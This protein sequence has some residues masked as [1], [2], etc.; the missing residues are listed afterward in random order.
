MYESRSDDNTAPGRETS[1]DPGWEAAKG[2]INDVTLLV[3]DDAA[4]RL[5][6]RFAG[7]SF[8]A[9]ILL[10]LLFD[11][12]SPDNSP[13]PEE[14]KE[15]K[16]R[17]HRAENFLVEDG[18]LW[19]LR[20]GSAKARDKVECI[21]KAETK[22]LALAVHSAGGHFGRDMTILALQLRYFWPTL[23][24]DVVETITSCPRWKNVGPRLLSAQL[25]PITRARPFDLIVGDYLSM[26]QGFN[27]FKTVLVLVNVYSRFAF[28]FPL[29]GPG[30]GKSTVNGLS[31]VADMLLMPRTFLAD[32]GSHFDCEEVREWATK[33]G[34]QL[35]KTPTYAPWTNGLAEG[36][37][38]LLIGRLKRLCAALLGQSDEEDGDPSSTPGSWPKHLA[39]AVAQLN[40]RVLPSLSYS[41]RELL[42]G[43]LSAERRAELS[44]VSREPTSQEVEVNMALTYSIRQDAYA[45]ALENANKRK[46]AFDKRVRE[47]VYKPGDLVQRYNT[48]WD[49]TH[50][51]ERELVPR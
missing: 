40:D 3:N 15:R 14:L 46:K 27:G 26:P 32:G 36:Y 23:C 34:V 18:K 43:Q 51:A 25:K 44:L 6:D 45:L 13:S 16:R 37:V 35:I 20:E 39:E 24:R 5:L 22:E 31:R 42:T 17:S 33:Q 29:H 4:A 30:T 28:A 8:F 12:G 47:I 50:S 11:T 7:D 2:M 1:V 48:R 38:S 19:L 10:H 9:D 21:P 41:P 49:E